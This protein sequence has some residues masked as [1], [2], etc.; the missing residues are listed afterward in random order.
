MKSKI[1]WASGLLLV[2]GVSVAAHGFTVGSTRDECPG[3]V[4]CP[5]SGEEVC[6]DRCPLID[7]SRT[8]CPGKIECPI[9]GELVCR[10]KCPLGAGKGEGQAESNLRPCC[11]GKK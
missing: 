9:T 11:R 6:K 5:I 1:I 3:K 2:L 7:A 4:V 8:D 10:D